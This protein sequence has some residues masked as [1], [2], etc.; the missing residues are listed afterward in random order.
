MTEGQEGK[1]AKLLGQHYRSKFDH[2]LLQRPSF[3]SSF[4]AGN[5]FQS[6]KSNSCSSLIKILQKG[7]ISGMHNLL[8]STLQSSDVQL[9]VRFADKIN[10]PRLRTLSIS[11]LCVYLRYCWEFYVLVQG[12]SRLTLTCHTMYDDVAI[13][14][15]GTEARSHEHEC[16]SASY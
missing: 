15:M 3:T 9:F 12:L 2:E 11:V 13:D 4:Y 6:Y 5:H 1:E 10:W 16:R 8:W 7:H 14:S